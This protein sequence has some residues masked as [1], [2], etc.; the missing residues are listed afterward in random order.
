MKRKILIPLLT[1][2]IILCSCSVK[3]DRSPCP[4]WLQVTYLDSPDIERS[5]SG[6]SSEKLFSTEVKS[7]EVFVE[8][9]VPRTFVTVSSYRKMPGISLCGNSILIEKGR[10]ADSLY[11]HC[12]SV[13]CR[14]ED[15]VDTV[16][17]HKQFSTVYLTFENTQEELMGRYGIRVKGDV[18][19]MDITSLCPVDGEFEFVPGEISE[20]TYRFRVPRQK[21]DSIVFELISREDGE[22]VDTIAAGILIKDMGFDWKARDLNDIVMTIDFS[23]VTLE[24]SVREW[25]SHEIYD[26]TI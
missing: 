24:V 25:D 7:R 10:Q 17:H 14:G 1:A 26:V 15:A 22:V 3:E 16:R 20:G 18:C 12:A 21:D 9:T 19:G 8:V 23:K 6:F 4:C 11:A 2:G 13:D 5:L